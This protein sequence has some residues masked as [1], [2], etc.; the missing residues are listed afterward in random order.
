[1]TSRRASLREIAALCDSPGPEDGVDPRLA[2]RGSSRKKEKAAKKDR[3]LA[4]QAEHALR[5][6]FAELSDEDG[7]G[8]VV[9]GVEPAPDSGHLRVIL[10]DE[11]T[12][13]DVDPADVEDLLARVEPLLRAAVARAVHRKRAP[14]LSFV[15]APGREE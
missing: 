1:M 12:D 14:A 9:L 13:Q 10:L 15:F 2:A 3:Q 7:D 4:K 6:A 5:L 11:R 8:I